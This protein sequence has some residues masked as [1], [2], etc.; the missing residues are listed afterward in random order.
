VAAPSIAGPDTTIVVTDT[1]KNQ[2]A[3]PSAASATA[4]Y[5]STNT[6][7]DAADVPLGSRTVPSLAAGASSSGSTPLAIPAATVTGTYFI[8]ARA[9]AVNAIVET[10]ENNNVRSSGAVRVGPDVIVSSVTVPAVAGA[11]ATI[12]AVDVTK[13]QG[14]GSVA[15]PPSSTAFYLSTNALFDAADRLLGSRSVPALASGVSDTGATPVEIPND[16]ATGAYYLNAKA[17]ANSDVV[18]SLETNNT[19]IA[20]IRIGP[21][22]TVSALSVSGTATAGGSVTI[23]D[24][25]KNV[26]GAT[27][28]AST[29]KFYVS[30]NGVVDVNDI[31]VG[32]RDVG[33]LAAGA[34]AA[35]TTLCTIP[36]GTPA[37]T[38]YLLG[39]A[40]S[41]NAVAETSET[42]NTA[43]A[44]IRIVP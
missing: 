1:T 7:L 36:P 17:D 29:T 38:F 34:S 12:A 3:G 10:L 39:V 18:E 31:L 9:D 30:T 42:N 43:I 19:K 37:G 22:L 8:L 24:T 40:D 16:T 23:A 27:A 13:N 33:S 15:A 14:A 11:G 32:S 5:L 41:G 4:F 2:G 21:D 6:L 26:G 35:A 25:T 44:F 20:A 28:G